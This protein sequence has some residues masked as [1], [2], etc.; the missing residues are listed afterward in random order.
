MID[1]AHALRILMDL[2]RRLTE[3]RSL[4]ASLKVIT[5]SALVLLGAQHSS[6]RILDDTGT[7]LLSGARSGSGADHKPITFGPGLGIAGWVVEHG[8]AALVR[9]TSED[10]RFVQF[11]GQGFDIG[12]ILAVPLYSAGKVIGV[13]AATHAETKHFDGD[14]EVLLRLL[15]NCAIPPIERTR[16]ERLAVTDSQTRAYNK[17]H[18]MPALREEMDRAKEVVVP[19]SVLLMD[20]DH[21]KLV[22]DTHGHQVGDKV[23]RVF[24]D[25]VRD[26]LRHQDVLIRRG[27][28]EFVL[29]MPA[30]RTE[31]AAAVAGRIRERISG[32]P[33]G[34]GVRQ[35]V[36][37]GVAT[38]DGHE[39]PEE[40][41]ERADQAMYAA[42]Q[43]GRDRVHTSTIFV[44]P[45]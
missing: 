21:F 17:R 41:E 2:T 29:I 24:A 6:M 44:D 39:S 43:A 31:E 28:E 25:R 7:E 14:H 1:A 11:T 13:L 16:L 18:L 38:W 22:N 9:D 35:T 20:L 32:K 34:P 30:T 15:A 10:K 19:M 40:L 4:E 27:G 12:S 26:L 8:I 3:E 23:L 33:I 42:K 5:D 45:S 36:S 37:I